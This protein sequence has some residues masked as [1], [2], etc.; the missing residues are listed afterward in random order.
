M[1]TATILPMTR[2]ASTGRTTPYEMVFAGGLADQHFTS[3]SEETEG[4]QD[5]VGQRDAFAR[6][7]SVA[8]LVQQLV[9]DEADAASVDRS[10]DLIFHCYHF[11]QAGCPLYAL[12]DATVRSLIEYAPNLSDWSPIAPQPV[13]YL[14]FPKNLLWATVTEGGSP[15]PVEGLFVRVDADETVSIFLILGMRADRPGFSAAGL[16]VPVS[17]A[18][19]LD[20]PGTFRSDVPGADL[21]GL[22]SIQRPREALLFALRVLWYFDRYPESAEATHVDPGSGIEDGGRTSLD[23]LVVRLVERSRG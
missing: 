1:R 5:V 11:W 18:K 17:D 6:L 16:E 19:E 23:Y 3:I 7:D 20:E 21:A 4:R 9:P 15:E 10:L 13:L 14:E 2:D 22:Y 12:E 8:A